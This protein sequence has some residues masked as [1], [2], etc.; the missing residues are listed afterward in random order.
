MSKKARLLQEPVRRF[1]TK[2]EDDAITAHFMQAN[3]AFISYRKQAECLNKMFHSG[4][5]VRTGSAVRRR[6]IALL[7][8]NRL[9]EQR[10]SNDGGT[11]P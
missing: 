11:T 5:P 7:K 10:G 9:A 2:E 1:W 6:E 3:G 8:P 4:K